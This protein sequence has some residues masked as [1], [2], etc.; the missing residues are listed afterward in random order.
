MRHS[1]FYDQIRQMLEE[2]PKRIFI[3]PGLITNSPILSD[4]NF[5]AKNNFIR[6]K[7]ELKTKW[8]SK[9][10][11]DLGKAVIPLGSIFSSHAT[12]KFDT[13]MG[14]DTIWQH[15]VTQDTEPYFIGLRDFPPYDEIMVGCG[16]DKISLFQELSA[17][18]YEYWVVPDMFIVH[19][20]ST[21]LG[22]AWCRS[23]SSNFDKKKCTRSTNPM[24]MG[25]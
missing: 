16:A 6:S 14:T 20:D 23:L 18:K 7:E 1:P 9:R 8:L 11:E 22:S 17:A 15:K 24:G 5:D 21:G 3:V 25:K 19:L 12:F 10:K 2:N 13:W 4:W